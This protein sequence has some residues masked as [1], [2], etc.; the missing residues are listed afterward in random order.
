MSIQ[1]AFDI[2]TGTL[3][4]DFKYNG[5]FEEFASVVTSSSAKRKNVAQYVLGLYPNASYIDFE[6][7][8][9]VTNRRNVLLE[10]EVILNDHTI[11]KEQDEQIE[12]T[13]WNYVR[14]EILEEID[15][16][17][18]NEETMQYRFGLYT[19]DYNVKSEYGV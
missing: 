16:H 19:C 2:L 9:D 13:I 12:N 8:Y 11:V 4:K 15:I 5:K 18:D 3:G 1:K 14:D 17:D 6:A 7:Y 10:C